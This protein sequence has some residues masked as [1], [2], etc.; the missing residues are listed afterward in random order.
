M[1]SEEEKRREEKR[2][3]VCNKGGIYN[4]VCKC[5]N[6]ICIKHRLNHDCTFDHKSHNIKELKK[7]NQQVIAEKIAP[8]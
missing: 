4:L 8:I 5:E 2:C 3:L 6:Y 7:K 1:P